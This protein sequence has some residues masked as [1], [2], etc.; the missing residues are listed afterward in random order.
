M[1]LERS[2]GEGLP[3]LEERCLW[4]LIE[5]GV[6]VAF[7]VG[8]YRR[9]DD[10]EQHIVS[11]NE[12]INSN[13][14]VTVPSVWGNLFQ[15]RV[16]KRRNH[17]IFNCMESQVQDHFMSQHGERGDDV[18]ELLLAVAAAYKAEANLS[19]DDDNDD[20]AQAEEADNKIIEVLTSSEEEETRDTK[21]RKQ[22]NK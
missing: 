14:S 4:E 8:F 20:G 6:G 9:G 1:S 5:E 2:V 16:T 22:D 19:D 3:A 15:W 18:R 17:S 12:V 11:V 21:R 10:L 13:E 7:N